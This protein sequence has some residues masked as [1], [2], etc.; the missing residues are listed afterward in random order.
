MKIGILILLVVG[1]SWLDDNTSGKTANATHAAG[2]QCKP[3]EQRFTVPYSQSILS[4]ILMDCE[5]RKPLKLGVLTINGAIFYTDSL[6]KF[7]KRLKPGHYR[8]RAGWPSYEFDSL[9]TKLK[10]RDSV[11]IVFYLKTDKRPLE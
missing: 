1:L 10:G 4:G 8:V 5:T 9:K 6:G 7:H 2:T 3:I 11:H